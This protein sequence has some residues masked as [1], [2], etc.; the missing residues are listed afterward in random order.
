[1]EPRSIYDS[2]P[3]PSGAGAH[4]AP[5]VLRMCLCGHEPLDHLLDEYG[6][7]PD[8]EPCKCERFR[9]ASACD[10]PITQAARRAMMAGAVRA[11]LAFVSLVAALETRAGLGTLDWTQVRTD[12]AAALRLGRAS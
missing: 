2:S 5:V 9:P 3:A 1:M 8:G 12:V 11:D 10:Q 6:C 7:F 4:P